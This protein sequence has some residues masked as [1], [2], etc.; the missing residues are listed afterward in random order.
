MSLQTQ[1][2]A[3]LAQERIAVVGVSRKGGTGKEIFK[4]LRKRGYEVV[5]VNTKTSEVLGETCYPKVSAID[6]GVGAVV[7]ATRA[8]MAEDVMRDCVEAGV[9][10]V[11]M[12]YNAL[13]GAKSSSV[14]Q[15]AADYGRE[16]GVEVIAGGCPL[17]FGDGADLGH[18]CMRWWLGVTKKLP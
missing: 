2:E 11:W 18:R 3:F 7:V 13:F 8:E 17:M 10:H 9:T 5:P 16:H 14:S 4:A 12:H 15:E 1:A 6:G